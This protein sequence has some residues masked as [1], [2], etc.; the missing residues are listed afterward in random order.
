MNVL[1]LSACEL[2][3]IQMNYSRK[4]ITVKVR[5][6]RQLTYYFRNYTCPGGGWPRKAAACITAP[7][8]DLYGLY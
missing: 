7:L 4:A 2:C 8:T 1:L 6:R 3:Y 5:G